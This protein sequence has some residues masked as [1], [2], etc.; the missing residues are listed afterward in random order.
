MKFWCFNF[1][2]YFSK[3]SEEYPESGVFSSCL[4][5]EEN[6]AEAE[7]RFHEALTERKINLI[8]I[9]ESF[10]VD[11]S[12]A[13]MDPEVESNL[14][15]IAWCEETEFAG[16]PVFDTFNLYPKEEVE[17]INLERQSN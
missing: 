6:Y 13:E 11:S 15:W 7:F 3:D 5:P 4:V 12:P 2:G 8:E 10:S 17:I 14:N 1:E 9:E 16:K